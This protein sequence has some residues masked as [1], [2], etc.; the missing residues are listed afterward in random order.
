MGIVNQR[1]LVSRIKNSFKFTLDL[2]SDSVLQLTVEVFAA[3]FEYKM[4]SSKLLMVS[5]VFKYDAMNSGIIMSY[6]GLSK[7]KPSL[8][9]LWIIYNGNKG[10]KLG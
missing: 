1:V 3:I 4:T 6:F 2:Y 5:P 8:R 9:V 7:T 10:V